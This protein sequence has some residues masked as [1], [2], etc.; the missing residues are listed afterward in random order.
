[1]DLRAFAVLIYRQFLAHLVEALVLFVLFPGNTPV[2]Q[3]LTEPGAVEIALEGECRERPT[4]VP[5]SASRVP[6]NWA[7]GRSHGSGP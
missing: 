1:V 6:G 2:E 7:E 4:W 3:V 5:A